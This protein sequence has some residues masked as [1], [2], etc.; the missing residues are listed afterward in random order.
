MIELFG[1][2][3]SLRKGSFNA[4]LLKAAAGAVPEGCRLETADIDGIPLYNA[5]VEAETGIPGK[6]A[7]LKDRIASCDGLLLV[8]PEYNNSIPGVFKNALDWISRPP[9]DQSRVFHNRPVGLIGATPGY[10][11]TAFSQTADFSGITETVPLQIAS[12]IHQSF[13]EVNEEGTEA[14]AATAVIMDITS[15]SP[16]PVF[17]ADH[18]FIFFIEHED[19]GQ[20]LFM[21]KVENPGA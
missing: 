15:I 7:E 8:T 20:I 11:G 9:Q 2:S 19:T 1:I 12:V 4:S 21:G 3:G 16:E 18:P 14:A 13:V 10:Y 6:V 5:D 17:Y